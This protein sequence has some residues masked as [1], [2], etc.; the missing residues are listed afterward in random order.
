MAHGP[1]KPGF[2]RFFG[3]SHV[4]IEWAPLAPVTETDKKDERDRGE[5]SGEP[6]EAKAY[7]PGDPRRAERFVTDWVMEE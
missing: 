1:C 2:G 7:A 3:W 6:E 4:S 5:R